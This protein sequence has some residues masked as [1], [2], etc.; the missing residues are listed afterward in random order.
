MVELCHTAVTDPAVLGPERPH[1][2]AGVAEAEDVAVA[3]AF[4]LVVVSNLFDRSENDLCVEI[5]PILRLAG[6]AHLWYSSVFLAR[7]PG[8]F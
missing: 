4:P 1:D 7:N 3:V 6:F 5:E 8:S 2:A